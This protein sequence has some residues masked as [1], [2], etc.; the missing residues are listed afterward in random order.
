MYYN[1]AAVT[2]AA[3]ASKIWTAGVPSIFVYD[4]TN[5]VFLGHGADNDTTYSAMTG[6]DGTNAGTSG[7]VPAPVATDNTK[8]LR[9]DGTWAPATPTVN[10]A[11]TGTSG[12][13]VDSVALDANNPTQ[14]NVTRSYVKI[15][16]AAGAPSTNTPTGFSEI[17]MN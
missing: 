16:I 1:G 15:P 12:Y 14:I 8:F 5:W 3:V 7:L 6:A 13:V 10:S 17:W 11:N 9:G 2:T 4:G